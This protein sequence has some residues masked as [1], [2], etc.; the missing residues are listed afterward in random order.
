MS[1]TAFIFRLEESG[2]PGGNLSTLISAKGFSVLAGDAD[3]VIL[4]EESSV[5][6]D[7]LML[8][9]AFTGSSSYAVSARVTSVE[10]ASDAVVGG[11]T[12]VVAD[13]PFDFSSFPSLAFSFAS[14]F[15]C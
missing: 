2:D 10:I 6:C 11:A 4:I 5:S 14:F 12:R 9:D 1:L 3:G 13:F 15:C 7:R 8:K